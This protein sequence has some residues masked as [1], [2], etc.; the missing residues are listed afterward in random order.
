MCVVFGMQGMFDLLIFILKIDKNVGSVHKH[1]LL[2]CVV[3]KYNTL[4]TNIAYCNEEHIRRILLACIDWHREKSAIN[5]R[6]N[7]KTRQNIDTKTGKRSKYT[8]YIIYNLDQLWCDCA[9]SCDSSINHRSLAL[10]KPKIARRLHSIKHS[11]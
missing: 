8:E 4:L 9:L 5:G 2:V 1:R 3:L 10:F 11:C 7:I 6:N